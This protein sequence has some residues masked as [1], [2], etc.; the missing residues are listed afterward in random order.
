MSRHL[1]SSSNDD[2]D[3]N[4]NGKKA[5]GLIKKKTTTTT[6]HL[7]KALL[8]IYLPSFHDYDVKLPNLTFCGGREQKTT[9]LF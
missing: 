2:G 9:T 3:G 7:H 1:G 5:V 8:Y 6:L 4:E